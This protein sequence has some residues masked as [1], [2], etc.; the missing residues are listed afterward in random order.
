M[1]FASTF[2]LCAVVAAAGDDHGDHDGHEH[3]AR[4]SMESKLEYKVGTDEVHFGFFTT[5]K[6]DVPSMQV[7]F[8]MM[9]KDH[10]L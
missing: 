5:L 7:H 1:R 4:D 2:A 9:S 3:G 6:G 10:N 8:K